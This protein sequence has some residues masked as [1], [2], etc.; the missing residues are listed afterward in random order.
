VPAREI[1]QGQARRQ[2]WL[3][4]L[5]VTGLSVAAI[6]VGITYWLGTDHHN[7]QTQVPPSPPPDVNQQL[8]GY[9]FTRSDQGHPVFTIH[10]AR[11]V[12]YKDSKSTTLDDVLVKV[13]GHKGDNGDL[14]RTDR[15]QYNPLTGDFTAAGPVQIEL[16]AYS[17]DIP[18][19][20]VRGKHRVVVETSKVDYHQQDALADTDAPVKFRMGSASGTAVGMTYAIQDGWM[21][22]KHNV[23]LELAQGTEKAPQAPI[24]LTASELRYNKDGGTMTLA[25]PVEVRQD[26]SHAAADNAT[27]QLNDHNRLSRVILMGNAK[28]YDVTPLRTVE[29]DSDRVQG[30]FDPFS[31]ELRHVIVDKAQMIENQ[32]N[33]SISHLSAQNVDMDIVGKQPRPLYGVAKGNVKL[34]MESQA[35]M[36]VSDKTAMRKATEKKS[37]SSS[38]VRFAF[39][40][41][42]QTLK[43]AETGGPGTLTI[44]PADPKTGQKVIDAGQFFMAFDDHSRI[45]SLR[46]TSPTQV[47]FL[48]APSAP[49]GT[50]P[51]TS[52]ADLLN[53][54]FDPGTQTLREVLQT[55]NF[56]YQDGDRRAS[57]DNA[58]YDSHAQTI[59]LLG[60]PQVWDP[61]NRVKSQKITIDMRTNTSTGEGKVQAVHLQIPAPGA[62]PSRAPAL[63]T[64]V[65]A[66]KMVARRQ[67]KT[68]NFEGHVRA[69]QGTDV[70]ES[71]AL[72]VFRAQKRVSSGSEV[73]TSFLQ[74]SQAKAGPDGKPHTSGEPRPVTIHAD[75]LEYLDEGRSAR[76]RGNVRMVTEGTTTQSDRL[77]VYLT[78]SQTMEGS[79][80][81]HAVAD[82]HVK[83]TQPGRVGTGDHAQY[84]A[85]PGKVVLTGG[86][87]MIVD[88]EN[89]STTGQRLTFFIRD[90]RLFVDGGDQ[91]PSLTQHRVAP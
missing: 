34:D 82:G 21:E 37:L 48:P 83:V 30:D 44:S 20:G 89:G 22:L 14:L 24:H 40:P 64:N 33:S 25:G 63:P 51:Q 88:E 10:A 69:W 16:S 80:I 46:G 8:S 72:D 85:G 47:T 3:T 50:T 77:D 4:A 84:F 7:G 75:S 53:A 1:G 49:P 17:G 19:S 61:D 28:A 41:G 6:A 57:A 59:L 43:H 31:G 29:M 18:D 56:Q 62:P 68:I 42:T 38:E 66:D 36:D 65:L 32:A 60:H 52:T 15:C 58:H 91:S 90:D 2:R 27:I 12:S 9:T 79:E 26:Q 86:P 55:G 70:V 78:Q 11:T 71:T 76:Y 87:P 54:V 23:A 67:S 35:V 13:Y 39:Q 5:V 81:D 74:P 73:M 45:E